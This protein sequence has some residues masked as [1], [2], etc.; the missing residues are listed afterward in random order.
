MFTR[1]AR[2]IPTILGGLIALLVVLGILFV[3]RWGLTDSRD[4]CMERSAN[5]GPASCLR[6]YPHLFLPGQ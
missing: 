3:F 2:E 1:I 5:P 4:I 6:E